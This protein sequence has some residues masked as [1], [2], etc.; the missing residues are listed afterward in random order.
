MPTGAEP[1]T[2]M[3]N[4]AALAFELEWLGAALDIIT[5]TYCFGLTI[6]SEIAVT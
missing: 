2:Q 3:A 5:V 6:F 4:E 1:L